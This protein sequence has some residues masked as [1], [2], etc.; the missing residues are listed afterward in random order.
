MNPSKL[1]ILCI[2]ALLLLI[3]ISG[4]TYDVVSGI[5][6][7]STEYTTTANYVELHNIS[8]ATGTGI[9]FLKASWDARMNFTAPLYGRFLRDGVSLGRF[10]LTQSVYAQAGS[11]ELAFNETT[12]THQYGWEVYSNK[13]GT[14]Y[15]RNF[16]AVFLKNGSYGTGQQGVDTD[17]NTSIS[18]LQAND[19]YFNGTV[20]SNSTNFRNDTITTQGTAIT[21][22]QS[23][24]TADRSYVNNTF[25][26]ISTYSG[27]FPN[28]TIAGY[29]GNYPNT[30]LINYLLISAYNGN[31]PNA[32]VAGNL[33]NWNAT[34]NSTYAGTATIVDGNL[35]NWNATY[36]STYNALLTNAPNTTVSNNLVNWNATYNASYA[37][38][39]LSFS[40][41]NG[42]NVIETGYSNNVTTIYAGTLTKLIAHS[43]QT[44][45]INMS[46][47]NATAGNTYIDSVV[48]TSGTDGN[49]TL[50]YAF[51]DETR[52][53][54]NVTSVADIKQVALT[55]KTTKS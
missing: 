15:S 16:S 19:T 14:I 13:K 40:I 33:A 2:T 42:T 32:T 5:A 8:L 55:V 50:S 21:A 49:K 18:A 3:P 41:E 28:T 34:Y 20:F 36:N 4:A 11:Y 12:G 43:A 1:V 35:A 44:G 46:F 47:W 39:G 25:L 22:L 48:I 23:N 53:M 29:N 6:S 38:G 30:S 17:Q 54:F 7:N 9:T 31:F 51:S 45:S 52:I 27:N 37:K 10:N 26:P 24:D